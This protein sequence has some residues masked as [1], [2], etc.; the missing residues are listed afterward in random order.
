MTKLTPAQEAKMKE[1]K[2]QHSAKHMKNMRAA[3]MKGKS[4]K[5]AHTSAKKADAS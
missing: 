5:A 4:F 1:H 3:M 2:K